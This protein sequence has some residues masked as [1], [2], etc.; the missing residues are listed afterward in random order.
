MTFNTLQHKKGFTPPPTFSKRKLVGGFTLVETLVAIAILLIAVVGPMSFVGNSLSQIYIARDQI[1]AVNLAQEGIEGV[2][3]IRDSNL[4]AR[5]IAGTTGA[6]YAPPASPDF[7]EGITNN[8]NCAT[9]C[10]L[11]IGLL[12]ALSACSGACT[13]QLYRTTSGIFTH[14][15]AGNE[16]TQFNRIVT[17]TVINANE[18]TIISTVTWKTSGDVMKTAEIRENLFGIN[19]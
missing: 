15:S 12:P 7:R 19:N 9:G 8:P 3:Q 4:L 10:A 6:G 1:V 18:I 11:E 13:G 14:S 5:W 2:R 17:A 16:K